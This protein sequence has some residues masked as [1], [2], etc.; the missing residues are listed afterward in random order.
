M[1]TCLASKTVFWFAWLV[2]KNCWLSVC[3]HA[4]M[5]VCVCVY[6]QH[7]HKSWHFVWWCRYLLDVLHEQERIKALSETAIIGSGGQINAMET[8]EVGG[9]SH[10]TT[11]E[12]LSAQTIEQFKASS[13]ADFIQCERTSISFHLFGLCCLFERMSL[14]SCINWWRQAQILLQFISI[15]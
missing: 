3:V 4:C 14:F 7:Q 5:C 1:E 6:L 8:A 11:E 12:D 10:W 9:M 15:H 2:T 13:L